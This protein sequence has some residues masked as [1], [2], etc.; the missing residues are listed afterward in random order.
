MVFHVFCYWRFGR[1]PLV[2]HILRQY[3]VPWV[4]NMEAQIGTLLCYKI[5]C[6]K[7][8]EALAPWKN[9]NIMSSRRN[10]PGSDGRSPGSYSWH[11]Y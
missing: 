11:G 6:L 7:A 4:E 5:G 2:L 3:E 9:T 10:H 1:I 8:E